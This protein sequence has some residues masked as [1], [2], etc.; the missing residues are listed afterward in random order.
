MGWFDNFLKKTGKLLD[1][2]AGC[3][4]VVTMLLTVFNILTRRLAGW[5]VLGISEYVSLISALAIGCSLANCAMLDGHIRVQVFVQKYP[6][7]VK[8]VINTVISIISF[9][10]F[11]FV[12]WQLI[13]YGNR[14]RVS[15]EITSTAEI[16]F[17]PFIYIIAF[18]IF[19]LSLVNL[20]QSIKHIKET[21]KNG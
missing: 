13:A 14:I 11:I 1:T 17:Y 4:I 3:G 21:G 8:K 7:A 5:S 9:I 20:L 6:I 12:T 18:G 2:I 16:P 19:F 10:F 15:G